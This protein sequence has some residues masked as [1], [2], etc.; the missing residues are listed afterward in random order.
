MVVLPDQNSTGEWEM[1]TANT[2]ESSNPAQQAANELSAAFI[3]SSLEQIM[4]AAGS[5]LRHYMPSS[6]DDLRKALRAVISASKS[7][8]A[9]EPF[10][11]NAPGA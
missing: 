3:D 5:S 7:P 10:P 4:R 8:P 1:G 2:A 9:L 6:Q 11:S